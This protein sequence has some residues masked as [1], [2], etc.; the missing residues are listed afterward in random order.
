MQSAA[1]SWKPILGGVALGAATI[2]HPEAGLVGVVSVV[3]LLARDR[4]YRGRAINRVALLAVTAR[5]VVL[6]WVTAV[7]VIV[8]YRNDDVVIVELER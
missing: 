7:I 1:E 5:L 6:P 4:V 2:W 3:V 8:A